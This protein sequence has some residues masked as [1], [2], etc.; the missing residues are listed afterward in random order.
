MRPIP[1]GDQRGFQEPGF[2][3]EVVADQGGIDL[4]LACDAAPG[5]AGVAEFSERRPGR[6]QDAF[7]DHAPA[8]PTFTS[9][10]PLTPGQAVQVS[11]PLG[12]S[13]TLFR[14]GETLRFI[15]AG[16]WLASVD[17]FLGQFPAHYVTRKSGPGRI[18]WGPDHQSHLLVPAIP[19]G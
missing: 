17:P 1:P 13:A 12:H 4:G 7:G 2:R 16:R 15:I 11:I 14:R 3:L 10:D 8:I 5:G 6:D 18:H 19:R 9:I